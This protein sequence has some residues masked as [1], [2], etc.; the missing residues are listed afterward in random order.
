MT[1]SSGR[2]IW[3]SGVVF[4]TRRSGAWVTGS[5]WTSTPGRAWWGPGTE[6]RLGRREQHNLGPVSQEAQGQDAPLVM[7]EEPSCNLR[8][9]VSPHT[10]S[11]KW[12]ACF[13]TSGVGWKEAHAAPS[14]LTDRSQWHHGGEIRMGRHDRRTHA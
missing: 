10:L 1:T 12:P 5:D 2:V 3:E 13:R 4:P 7:L 6:R 14:R 8:A 9:C 11:D